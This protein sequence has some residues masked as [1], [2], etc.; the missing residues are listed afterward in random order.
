MTK[1][2]L[3]A[4]LLPAVTGHPLWPQYLEEAADAYDDEEWP[5]LFPNVE[6][7]V[8]DWHLFLEALS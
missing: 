6:A 3:I 2:E 1:Q 5:E 8:H 7:L 4:Q